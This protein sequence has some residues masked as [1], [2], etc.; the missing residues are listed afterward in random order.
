MR[1]QFL[2]GIIGHNGTGKSVTA[3]KIAKWWKNNNSGKV[4]AHDPTRVLHK[5]VDREIFP[6][7]KWEDIVLKEMRD[8]LLILDELRVLHP[9]PRMTPKLLEIMS[10]R[11]M[12]N[13]DIVYIVHNPA[14]ILEQLTYYTTHYYIYYTQS[15]IG[16]FKSKIPNY[17]LCK[18]ASDY[19]NRYVRKNGRGDYP[20]FPY[21]VVDCQ[22]ETIKAINIKK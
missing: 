4:Y 17:L 19:I 22:K 3:A 2:M 20:K 14:L 13:I 5:H 15:K 10:M 7:Q 12:Y 8:G 6:H 16:N 9:N 18:K 1:D 11:R 21:V